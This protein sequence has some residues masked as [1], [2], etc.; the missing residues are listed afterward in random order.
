M[1]SRSRG[2]TSPNRPLDNCGLGVSCTG[3][4]AKP[5]GFVSVGRVQQSTGEYQV[6]SARIPR[7]W[8]AND[9]YP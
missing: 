6:G 4:W 1:T 5:C 3:A 2:H 8:I 9:G 7:R